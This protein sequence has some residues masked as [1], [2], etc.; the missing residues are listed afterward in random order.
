MPN[1]SS[2]RIIPIVKFK[3]SAAVPTG[4]HIS[5]VL[6]TGYSPFSA[7]ID[8]NISDASYTSAGGSVVAPRG[9]GISGQVTV[10]SASGSG[11]CV[12]SDPAKANGGTLLGDSID[13]GVAEHNG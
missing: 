1:T 6:G 10:S 13:I 12:I 2:L 5:G 3:T 4:V 9:I 11:F 7:Y 8:C